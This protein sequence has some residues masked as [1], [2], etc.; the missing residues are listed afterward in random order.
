[1]K[2]GIV[3]AGNMA[4]GIARGLAAAAGEPG[5]PETL[6]ISDAV[7]EKARDL[8]A[9]V[10]AEPAESNRALAEGADLVVL[11]VKPNALG[12]VAPALAEA[13]TPVVSILAGTTLG[14]LREALPGIAL[15]RVMPNLGAELRQAVLW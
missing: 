10:G 3:G 13:G 4:S 1:M 5:A 14:T 15:V 12:E 7:A 6:L 2:L 11:A 9:E 8:A